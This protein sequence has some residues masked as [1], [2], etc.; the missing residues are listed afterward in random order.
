[1]RIHVLSD[2][3]LGFGEFDPPRT[4]ADVVVLAGD[5]DQGLRGVRWARRS[6]GDMPVLYVIGNHEYYGQALPKLTGLLI[7]E[8]ADWPVRVLERSAVV[9]DGIRFVGCTLW[10]DL[11]LYGNPYLAGVSLAQVMTDFRAI[12]L[13]PEYRRFR[14]SDAA[15][16]HRASVTWLK[17][18]WGRCD[19]P[20][21]VV[22]HH[23]PSARSLDMS[24]GDDPVN[25]GYASAL[26]PLI[27][28]Q[29]PVAWIHGHVHRAVDYMLGPTRIVCNP[30]GYSDEPSTGFD[31]GLII[32]V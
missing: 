9:L 16:L 11:A 17:S 22:S 14:P 23:A 3:H 30:R 15:S 4:D 24:F 26:E 6:F 32:T 8:G 27:E 13:S 12:R 19:L 7:A 2:L 31:P 25:A 10:T 1:M 5:I 21:V 18:E 20:T 28:S 29:Q